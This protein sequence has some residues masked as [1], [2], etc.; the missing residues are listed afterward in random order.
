M[1]TSEWLARKKAAMPRTQTTASAGL[2]E[3]AGSVWSWAPNSAEPFSRSTSPEV[4][5][6]ATVTDSTY[7]GT[8]NSRLTG[9]GSN[10][11]WLTAMPAPVA[12]TSTG[13]C[14]NTTPRTMTMSQTPT[15]KRWWRSGTLTTNRSAITRPAAYSSGGQSSGQAPPRS[16]R[17]AAGRYRATT[18]V[19]AAA[20]A[21]TNSQAARG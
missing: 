2:K 6:A 13:V 18:T 7:W 9:L 19:A 17:A 3:L 5:T 15:E 1:L 20:T 4:T 11:H 12:S 10:S 14:R 16:W 21:R 8:L